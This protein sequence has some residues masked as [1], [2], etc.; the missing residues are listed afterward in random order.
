MFRDAQKQ[1]FLCSRGLPQ[2]NYY[3]IIWWV[4]SDFPDSSSFPHLPSTCVHQ[5]FLLHSLVL[6]FFLLTLT[7]IQF[8]K[9]SIL[10]EDLLGGL[11]SNYDLKPGPYPR[12]PKF[13]CSLDLQACPLGIKRTFSME[14][15]ILSS[16]LLHG[17]FSIFISCD[18]VSSSPSIWRFNLGVILFNTSS[19]SSWTPVHQISFPIV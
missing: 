8:L 14:L 5:G 4:P 15:I 17:L 18:I 13:P 16:Q 2:I 6:S 7:P 19:I 12:T 10:M 9:L 1:K 11:L 3:L